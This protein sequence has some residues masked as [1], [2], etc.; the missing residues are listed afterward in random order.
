M[1]QSTVTHLADS[2]VP[3]CYDIPALTHRSYRF[4]FRPYMQSPTNTWLVGIALAWPDPSIP[5][6]SRRY[7]YA[8]AGST[9]IGEYKPGDEFKLADSGISLSEMTLA[10]EGVRP[11]IT[12]KNKALAD[13]RRYVDEAL[14]EVPDVR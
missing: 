4:F 3:S 2:I 5:L 9:A 8:I 11:F 6:A 12:A 7:F 14:D 10:N 1:M 13:L